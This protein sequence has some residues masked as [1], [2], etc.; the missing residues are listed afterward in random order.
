MVVALAGC[1]RDG[2]D[3]LLQPLLLVIQLYMCC[4]VFAAVLQ[5]I[6]PPLTN[7]YCFR[8]FRAALYTLHIQPTILH[9]FSSR[10]PVMQPPS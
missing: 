3:V 2:C 5:Y 9:D 1:S 6:S 4:Y 8:C 7:G 10:A